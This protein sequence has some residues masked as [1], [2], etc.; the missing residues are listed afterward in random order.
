MIEYVI[1]IA[2]TTEADRLIVSQDARFCL[3]LDESAVVYD[4]PVVAGLDVVEAILSVVRSEIEATEVRLFGA[5]RG[6]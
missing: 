4:G 1:T 6:L 3:D 5:L 2:H